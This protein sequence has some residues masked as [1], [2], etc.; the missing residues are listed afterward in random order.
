MQFP[1]AAADAGAVEAPGGGAVRQEM[2]GRTGDALVLVA[3]DEGQGHLGDQIRVFAES[4]FHA[5]PAGVPCD[6]QHGGEHLIDAQGEGFSGAGVGHAA[7]KRGVEGTALGQGVREDRTAI[8]FQALDAFGAGDD[9]DAEP[10]AVLQVCSGVGDDYAV[11][12]RVGVQGEK[13]APAL[14]G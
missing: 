5:S 8:D 7:D 6:I 1:F 2:L 14:A 12:R 4:L 3:A 10:R 13:R 11:S 9:R